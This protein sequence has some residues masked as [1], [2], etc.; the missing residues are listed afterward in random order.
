MIRKL[1][2]MW[3]TAAVSTKEQRG[4]DVSLAVAALM[5]EVMRMDGHLHEA[6]RSSM[7]VALEKRFDL[8]ETEIHALIE[9]ASAEVDKALDLHQFT[10]IVVKGFSTQ[11]RIVILTELWAVAMADGI[12]DPYEEQIIRR[13]ADLL[14][15]H[16]TQF[17]EAKLS[18]ELQF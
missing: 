2:K 5:V 18:A 10:S 13:M 17:I 16:H 9:Q 4:H 14:G 12:V 15:I 6:E 11:E 7:M 1:Q 8:S 3:K